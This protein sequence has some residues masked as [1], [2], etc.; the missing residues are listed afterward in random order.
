MIAELDKYLLA[1]L[2]DRAR[3]RRAGRQR[4][5]RARLRASLQHARSSCRAG[6]TA[7]RAT[8]EALGVERLRPR[9]RASPRRASTPQRADAR[10]LVT[11]LH[12]RDI[13]DD[14]GAGFS[15]VSEM[16]DERNRQLAEVTRVDDVIVSDKIISLMLTQISENR[17]LAEVFDELF[18]AEGSEIYLR[19]ASDYVAAGRETTYATVVEAA[20]APRRVRDRLPR[21]GRRRRPRAATSASASTRRSPSGHARRAATA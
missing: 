2:G 11:L 16:L 4:V 5:R 15:I 14:G 9:D 20:R 3:H 13:A 19:P 8:L 17:E 10:T 12:L 1:G 21:R 6:N 18:A 7:D